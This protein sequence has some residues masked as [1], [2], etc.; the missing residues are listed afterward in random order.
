MWLMPIQLSEMIQALFTYIS[1]GSFNPSE[2]IFCKGSGV[3]SLCR[4]QS[5]ENELFPQTQLT[6]TSLTE[7]HSTAKGE[8][9]MQK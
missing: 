7:L 3:V 4:S 8:V 6:E 1:S 2:K 5:T 9:R